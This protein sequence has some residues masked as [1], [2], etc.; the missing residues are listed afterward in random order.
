MFL[1]ESLAKPHVQAER[2]FSVSG[3]DDGSVIVHVVLHNNHLLVSRREACRVGDC[4]TL[5]DL[6]TEGDSS[7]LVSL[8]S[9]KEGIDTKAIETENPFEPR[10]HLQ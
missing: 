8:I 4:N 1:S 5:G 2:S 7:R 9:Q 3:C 10:P 6:L